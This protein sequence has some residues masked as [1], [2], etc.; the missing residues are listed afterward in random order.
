MELD[1]YAVKIKGKF[2]LKDLDGLCSYLN[3]K[4]PRSLSG[5]K[6]LDKIENLFKKGNRLYMMGHEVKDFIQYLDISKIVEFNHEELKGL[7]DLFL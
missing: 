6:G 4:V 7:Y 2:F 5:E 3:I 1:L